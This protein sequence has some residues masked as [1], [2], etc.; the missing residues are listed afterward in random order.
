MRALHGG[1]FLMGGAMRTLGGRG[2]AFSAL[3]YGSRCKTLQA[4]L[5]SRLAA[6]LKS[7]LSGLV[8]PGNAQFLDGGQMP[9]AY[10]L[11]L[12]LLLQARNAGATDDIPPVFCLMRLLIGLLFH[13]QD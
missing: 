10:G 8:S 3:F 9:V 5:V 11:G 12:V 7:A 13:F 6:V 4:Q 2:L 1:G